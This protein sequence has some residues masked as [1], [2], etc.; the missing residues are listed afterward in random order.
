MNEQVALTEELPETEREPLAP[1][2][3]GA[4]KKAWRI[5]KKILIYEIGRAHV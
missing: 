2:R 4:Q 3:G 5:T 1:K